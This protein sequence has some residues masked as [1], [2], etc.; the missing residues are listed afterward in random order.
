M[1]R[2]SPLI[3]LPLGSGDNLIAATI[4][5]MLGPDE[6]PSMLVAGVILGAVAAG[7]LL[8]TRRM[9]RHDALPYGAFP[10]AS[11]LIALAVPGRG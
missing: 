4:G 2:T 5:A 1:T 6:M 9:G 11:A 3:V 7:L 8:L 10:C